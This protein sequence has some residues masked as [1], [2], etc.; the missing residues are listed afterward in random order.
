MKDLIDQ[1]QEE[2]SSNKTWSN[3]FRKAKSK[4]IQFPK[5]PK[6]W[7]RSPIMSPS[8]GATSRKVS[9]NYQQG[10]I[11]MKNIK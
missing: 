1:I 9:Q 2:K 3:L 6:F 7:S 10:A 5:I 11:K 4:W 8:R